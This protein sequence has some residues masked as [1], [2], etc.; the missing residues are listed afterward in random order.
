MY[1]FEIPFIVWLQNIGNW[2]KEPML[3]LSFL[4]TQNAY[5]L[6]M[7]WLYWCLDCQLGIQVGI[8]LLLSNGITTGLKWIFKT[9]RP[10]WE[11]L[12]VFAFSTESSFGMPSGHALISTSV[13]GRFASGMKKKLLTIIVCILVFGIGLSRVYLGVHFPSDVI[14][15]WGIGLMLLILLMKFE[16][17]INH[18]LTNNNV[19]RKILLAFLSSILIIVIFLILNN[20]FTDWQ[21]PA[22]WINNAEIAAPFS[23]IDPVKLKD[24][25][26]LSGSWFGMLA[27][28][29]WLQKSG[30]MLSQGEFWQLLLRFLIGMSGIVTLVYGMNSILPEI[31][32][33]LSYL[34]T[35]IQ[36]FLVS[37]WISLAAPLLFI[38]IGVSEKRSNT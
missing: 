25:F 12:Q 28:W 38:K 17:S 9:P 18:W 13:W 20:Q 37:L 22:Q 11:S 2:L 21:L 6:L 4:G 3:F 36:Y 29:I 27:G 35:Y 19:P 14:A 10:Y 16:N 15:G 1:T 23:E 31:Q 24:I 34:I 30:G 7:S 26:I 32:S 8:G 5:F 33:S